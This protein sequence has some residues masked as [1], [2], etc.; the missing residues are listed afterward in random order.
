MVPILYECAWFS[1]K[2]YG[3][4]IALAIGSGLILA[5]KDKILTDLLSSE[6]LIDLT[7]Y[8]LLSGII[9]GRILF[10]LESNIPITSLYEILAVW[11]GGL[12]VSGALISTIA[13]TI[14][15]LRSYKISLL[16][17]LDHLAIYV[18]LIYS[19]SRIGCFFAGCCHGITSSGIFCISY[20]H[21]ASLAATHLPVLPTQLISSCLLFCCFLF[22]YHQ[23]N[24]PFFTGK[25]TGYFLFFIGLERFFIDFIRYDHQPFWLFFSHTQLISSCF[26]IAGL[27]TLFYNKVIYQHL[28][29]LNI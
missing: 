21:P 6:K 17:T 1:I 29:R 8:L 4:F 2:S 12:S 11:N 26:I 15:Y 13:I 19:I 23:K 20:T 16:P 18:L 27:I 9:G 25:L 5:Q 14:I 28:K 7:L 10:L 24:K 22:L 3:F